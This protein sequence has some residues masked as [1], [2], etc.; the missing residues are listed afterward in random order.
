[1]FGRRQRSG[2]EAI[3]R[4]IIGVGMAIFAVISYLG[5]SS[6]NEV[7]GENQYISLTPNQ[8]I[9]LGYQAQPEIVQQFGGE[10]NDRRVQEAF[11]SIGFDIIRNS[12]A[13][14]TPW[15]FEF[16][17]LD[18]PTTVNAFALP[19]GPIFITTGLLN[20]L[21]TEDQVAGVI[22]HEIVHVLARHGAQRI[23][24][25]DLTNGLLGAV[26]VAAGDA[27]A[28]QLAAVVAQLVN[29]R[30][31]REDEIQ[32]DTLG[33]CLMLSAGYDPQGMVEVM[34]ILQEAAGD[35]RQPEFMSSHPDPGNRIERIQ[36]QIA[37]PNCP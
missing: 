28:S 19:G 26:G 2:G 9:A 17:V 6:Y 29:L 37:N 21:E 4:I 16:T 1:M 7:T 27:S 18:D 31:G 32:S 3:I 30:Y 14:D 22:A 23:A 13:A 12:I 34:E 20:R 15:R 11:D 33:V 36:E 5:S 25:S 10:F 8:E 24:Q 35:Q